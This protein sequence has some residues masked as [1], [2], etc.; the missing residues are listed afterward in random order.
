MP[1]KGFKNYFAENDG[2][3]YLFMSIMV[4]TYELQTSWVGSLSYKFDS[5]DSKYKIE[6]IAEA[7]G[8]AKFFT[9]TYFL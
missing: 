6:L 8:W 5:T 1:A 3:K 7:T 9:Q 4:D 2:K